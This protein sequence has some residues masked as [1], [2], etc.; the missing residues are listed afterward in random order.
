KRENTDRI[1]REYLGGVIG[2]TVH[3]ARS[4]T[5]YLAEPGRPYPQ[6]DDR[7]RANFLFADRF[8]DKVELVDGREP[9][10]FAGPGRPAMEV[11]MG[12]E[13]A[14]KLGV[15]LGDSFDLHPF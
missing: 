7:P 14:A 9:E 2:E 15:Q 3:I 6:A 13:A 11:L 12:D 10:P 5:F 1:L 4:A 8:M